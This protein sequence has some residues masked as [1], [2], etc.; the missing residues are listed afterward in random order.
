M[1]EI[2]INETFSDDISFDLKKADFSSDEM[3][4][5][6]IEAKIKHLSYL[7]T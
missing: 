1:T 5:L 3:L 4:K 7:A 2:I 6:K